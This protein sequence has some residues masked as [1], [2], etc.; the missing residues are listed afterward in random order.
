[1]EFCAWYLKYFNTEGESTKT[2]I[3]GGGMLGKFYST[4]DPRAQRASIVEAQYNDEL[5]ALIR[6]LNPE[7]A[8]PNVPQV[9]GLPGFPGLHPDL[10]GNNSAAL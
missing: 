5:L 10:F 7:I 2:S 4:Y 6:Q 9:P 1:M 3:D 8:T